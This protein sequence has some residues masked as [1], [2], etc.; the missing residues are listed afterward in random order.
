MMGLRLIMLDEGK[1]KHLS[2]DFNIIYGQ[3][4]IYI[5][6]CFSKFLLKKHN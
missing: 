6:Y 3:H 4:I 2:L 1:Y 5:L